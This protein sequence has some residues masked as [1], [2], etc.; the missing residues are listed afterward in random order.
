MRNGVQ[1]AQCNATG[2]ATHKFKT[3]H[4]RFDNEMLSIFLNFISAFA[5][6]IN[7]KTFLIE[8]LG[9]VNITKL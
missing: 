2:L 1:C 4:H 7:V 3:S 5:C 9:Y 6:Y 8:D